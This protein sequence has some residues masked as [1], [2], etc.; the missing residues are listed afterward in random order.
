MHARLCRD[1][2]N[3]VADLDGELLDKMLG[4]M[5]KRGMHMHAEKDLLP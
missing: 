5:S 3:I 4:Y 1:E 2:V